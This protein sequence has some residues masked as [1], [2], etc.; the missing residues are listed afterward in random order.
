[1]IIIYCYKYPYKE[2]CYYNNIACTIRMSKYRM[3]THIG[4]TFNPELSVWCGWYRRSWVAET[5]M[6]FFR[7]IVLYVYI[8]VWNRIVI[9][10]YRSSLICTYVFF[11]Y[12]TAKCTLC[13]MG[14][15]MESREMPTH[16]LVRIRETI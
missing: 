8:E 6:S 13:P 9:N 4:I 7:I 1:M 11:F 3:G 5:I 12:R 16:N 10:N 15:Y 2:K 14:L